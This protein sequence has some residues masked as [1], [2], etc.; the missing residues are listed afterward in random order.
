[1]IAMRGL[2]AGYELGI[3]Q[4]HGLFLPFGESNLTSHYAY[5]VL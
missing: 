2:E 1:M 5:L 4:T 3:G